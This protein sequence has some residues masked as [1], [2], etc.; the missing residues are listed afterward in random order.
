[1][2]NA[3]PSIFIIIFCLIAGIIIFG[4]VKGTQEWN[5]NNNSPILEVKATVVTKRTDV[6]N[7][8]NNQAT[9]N[10]KQVG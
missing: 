4:I 9:F 10:K 7:N 1:M 5:K 3:F 6:F 2:F 8:I